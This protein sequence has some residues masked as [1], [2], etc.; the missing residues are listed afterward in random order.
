MVPV[1]AFRIEPYDNEG[2]LT[3]D[4]ERIEFGPLQAEMLPGVVHVMAPNGI[5]LVS[6][7]REV[8]GLTWSPSPKAAPGRPG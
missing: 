7:H 4:G 6:F 5:R 1:T 3:V 8:K 2:I